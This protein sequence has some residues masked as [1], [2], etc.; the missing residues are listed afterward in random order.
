MLA[1]ESRQHQEAHIASFA[2]HPA[3]LHLGYYQSG[4]FGFE[5]RVA[6]DEYFIA[7][8][9]RHD[10]RA[11]LEATVAAFQSSAT[12][13]DGQTAQCL[14]PARYLLLKRLL[15]DA[16]GFTDQPCNRFKDWQT[17]LDAHS[18]T[19]I[20]PTS[21]RNNPASM[22]GHTLLRLDQKDQSEETRMLS[23]AVNY[24]A[25]TGG[26]G[27]LLYA[28][29]GVLGGYNG[30]FTVSPYYTMLRR[31]SDLENRDIWEYQL[32]FS[33]A[34][35]DFL[36]RHLWELRGVAF[37]YYYFDENCS[38][39]LLALLEAVRPDLALTDRFLIHVIPIDTVRATLD[40]EGVLQKVYFRPSAST[41]IHGQL[42]HMPADL[43]E[44]AL[45]LV[46]ENKPLPEEL[47]AKQKSQVLDL[48]YELLEYQRLKEKGDSSSLESRILQVLNQRSA[49]TDSSQIPSGVVAP[50]SRS[51]HEAHKTTRARMGYT[52]EYS[53]NMLDVELRPA[54]HDTL[55]F[56]EGYT[57]GFGIDFLDIGFRLREQSG[58]QL[59]K[60]QVLDVESLSPQNR[61]FSPFSWQFGTGLQRQYFQPGDDSLQYTTR[62]AVGKS[63]GS[64]SL[65]FAILPELEVPAASH[66]EDGLDVRTGLYLTGL[67]AGSRVGIKPEIRIFT[68]LLFSSDVQ[69]ETR[70]PLRLTITPNT[71]IRLQWE[72][73]WMSDFSYSTLGVGYDYF[74]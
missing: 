46:E 48:T 28:A 55:D 15:G 52:R 32:A 42:D 53:D 70:V 61:F 21:Y 12:L 40:Q 16:I 30:Y 9:G 3:W 20:F 73:N 64:E 8:S 25:E 51:P 45:A 66:Y 26:E 24:A 56:P 43:Q 23:Y 59:G 34:D 74:W 62:L 13:R 17:A 1:D 33:E 6:S 18:A 67:R 41:R 57:P 5:S 72:R 22:F 37:R 7:S 69:V 19:L 47:N 60:L 54:Y 58:L 4:I 2:T 50:S 27:A 49:I 44:A 63:W 14:F 36:V 10:P 31:Y 38:Y 71:A 68:S 35:I 11:E 65:L 29:K 39:Q